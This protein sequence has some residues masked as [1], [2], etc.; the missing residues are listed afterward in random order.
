VGTATG[1]ALGASSEKKIAD[2]ELQNFKL[3]IL[4]R[5]AQIQDIKQISIL[6]DDII[7]NRIDYEVSREMTTNDLIKTLED[8]MKEYEEMCKKYDNDLEKCLC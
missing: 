7:N 6:H 8:N 1:W 5:L 4:D 3:I 2:Q